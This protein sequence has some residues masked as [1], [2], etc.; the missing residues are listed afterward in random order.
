VKSDIAK[1]LVPLHKGLLAAD[2]STGTIKKRF[3]AVGLVSSPELNRQYR[4]MLFTT[5]GIENFLSGV[6]MFDETVRQ[7]TDEGVPFPE[8][9]SER[10]IIPGIKVDEGREPLNDTEEIA[11]G[12]DGLPERLKEYKEMRVG[13]TKWRAPFVISSIY[14]SN[15]ALEKNIERMVKYAEI[16]QGYDLVPIVEPEVLMDGNHTTARCEEV[17]REVLSNLFRELKMAGIDLKKLL[18]KTNMILPGKDSNVKADSLEV[19]HATLRT[20]RKTVP[21]EVPGI[22]FLSGGQSPEEA[23]ANLDRI[24]K[25]RSDSPWELSFSFARA[26]QLEPL[27][28]WRGKEENVKMAQGV[29]YKRAKLVSLARQGKYSPEMER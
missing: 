6:I 28:S 7:K 10:G 26:L 13:F 22:V 14:P 24:N 20:M 27:E 23:T 18:L 21:S 9:L 29:F 3:A 25:L 17:S 12:L 4:Q 15:E 19:A 1:K 16:S 8:Y 2:E 5:P 11:R